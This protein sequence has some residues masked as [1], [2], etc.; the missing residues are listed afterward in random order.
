[1]ALTFP[2]ENADDDEF[3]AVTEGMGLLGGQTVLLNEVLA[4][5]GSRTLLEISI[6]QDGYVDAVLAGRLDDESLDLLQQALTNLR[7]QA[8]VGRDEHGVAVLQIT[9]RPVS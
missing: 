8:Q 3:F 4:A 2:V 7:G 5:Q 6:D 9:S 1:M